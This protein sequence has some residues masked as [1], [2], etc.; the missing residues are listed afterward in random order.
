MDSL[1]CW[2][3]SRSAEIKET[4]AFE[5]FLT[6][7]LPVI[8]GKLTSLAAKYVGGRSVDGWLDS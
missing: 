7:V 8:E 2:Q 4:Q 1:A 5:S 3:A 6:L